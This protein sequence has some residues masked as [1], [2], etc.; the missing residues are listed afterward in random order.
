MMLPIP[1]LAPLALGL[2]GAIAT[3]LRSRRVPNTISF[4]VLLSGLVVRGL[5]QGF[6]AALSGVGAA[7]LVVAALYRP[8]LMGG[9]GGGDVKLAGAVAAWVSFGR[10]PWFAL[11]AALAGGVVAA[12]CYLLARADGRAAIRTNLTLAVLRQEL[13]DAPSHRAGHL[14]VPYA[15]AIACGGVAAFFWSA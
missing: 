7:A 8:W 14:S 2:L 12:V 13:P 1:H 3:D 15:L 5:D 10:L 9:I 4:F 11:T 6:L